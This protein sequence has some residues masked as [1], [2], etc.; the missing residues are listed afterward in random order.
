MNRLIVDRIEEN[1]IV[2]ENEKGDK[3]EIDRSV[4]E[5]VKD[6][7]CIKEENG[8]YTVDKLYTEERRKKIIALQNDLWE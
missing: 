1:I 7:D 4:L 8:V 6:G 5:K 2:C 3:V